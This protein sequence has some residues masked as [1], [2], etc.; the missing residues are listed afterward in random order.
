MTTDRLHDIET[1]LR[2]GVPGPG[3]VDLAE[4]MARADAEGLVDVAWT[5]ID[6]PIGP[7]WLAAT[8]VGLL[9]V[10]FGDPEPGLADIARKLSPRVVEMPRRLDRTRKELDE[11]FEGRRRSFDLALDRRMSRGFRAEV[12]QALER[13][14][15]G[16]TLSYM[17]LAARAGNP[18]ASRAVGSAMATNP[19]P[20][21]VPCHRV[22][23]TG[24][25]LGG[26]GGGLDAKRWLLAHEGVEP[27][28]R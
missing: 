6:S 15:F 1:R 4:L 20:I 9:T 28:R 5:R 11:Y 18:K 2:A 27:P 13:V 12:L 24:G 25:A 8:D 26:Y 7:L 14:A 22:L 3:R 10:G 19:I 16:E 17:D 23:R 21:V